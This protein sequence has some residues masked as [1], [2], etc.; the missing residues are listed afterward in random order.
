MF[1]DNTSV[2]FFEPNEDSYEDNDIFELN[3]SDKKTKIPTF[4]E[5]KIA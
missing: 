5:L 3:I 4:R 2:I 1:T